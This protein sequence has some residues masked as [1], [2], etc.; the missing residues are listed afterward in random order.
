MFVCLESGHLGVA[1]WLFDHGAAEDVRTAR[2]FDGWTPMMA[3]CSQ[4]R[5]PVAQWLY[6]SG[7]AEDVRRT[8]TSGHTPMLAVVLQGHRHIAEWLCSLPPADLQTSNTAGWNPLRAALSLGNLPM[9]TWLLLRGAASSP[10][11]GHVD[12]QL[13]ERSVSPWNRP[14]LR[15]SLEEHRA[16]HFAFAR[17]LLPAVACS[18]LRDAEDGFRFA[19]PGSALALLQ[20]LEM[21]VLLHV[22]EFVGVLRGRELR[23]VNQAIAALDNI[24]QGQAAD[25][26]ENPTGS[27][28]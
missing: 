5:L 1:Q 19:P 15:A 17:V 22:S 7:A 9:A 6:R 12:A 25:D 16:A 8:S 27:S 21:A 28:I 20:G 4:G 18:P 2:R 3:A 14:E 26:D 13:I 23:N 24:I 11:T 10:A